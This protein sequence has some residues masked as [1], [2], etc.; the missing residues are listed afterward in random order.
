MP[1][2]RMEKFFYRLHRLHRLHG[3][4]NALFMRVSDVTGKMAK[5]VTTG[6]TGYK[7]EKPLLNCTKEW[8]K[9]VTHL[10]IF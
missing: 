4:A 6:Y 2:A 3:L 10:C 7:F 8:S 5:A 9:H 1:H